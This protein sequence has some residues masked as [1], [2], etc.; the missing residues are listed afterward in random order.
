MGSG[1][2]LASGATPGV[3]NPHRPGGSF[4]IE[5]RAIA[6]PLIGESSSEFDSI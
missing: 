3:F 5:T 1:I 6:N 4:L 2:C